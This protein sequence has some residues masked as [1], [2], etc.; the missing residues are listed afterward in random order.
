MELSLMA[1]A[2]FEKRRKMEERE[3]EG[4]MKTV[5]SSQQSQKSRN[6]GNRLWFC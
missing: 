4:K 6:K 1:K 2:T 5:G 3:T